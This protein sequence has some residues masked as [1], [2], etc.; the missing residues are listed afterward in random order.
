METFNIKTATWQKFLL[1]FLKGTEL[2]ARAIKI[3]KNKTAVITKNITCVEDEVSVD[4]KFNIAVIQK[5]AY[6]GNFF[7]GT[8]SLINPRIFN[9]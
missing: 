7:A 3:K 1:S 5:K 6:T 8:N 9:S 2:P 4:E